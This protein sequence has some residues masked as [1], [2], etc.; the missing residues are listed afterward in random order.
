VTATPEK[1]NPGK[2]SAVRHSHPNHIAKYEGYPPLPKHDSSASGAKV[3][4]E[5]VRE[6][7]TLTLEEASDALVVLRDQIRAFSTKHFKYEMTAEEKQDWPLADLQ[8]KYPELVANCAYI[9][10]GS[11]YG[12]RQ[13]FTESYCRPQLVNGLLGHYLV[14]HVFKHTCFG[15]NAKELVD[16][17]DDVLK[18][19]VHWDGFVRSKQLAIE[20]SAI[21]AGKSIENRAFDVFV[22]VTTL[23]TR[24]LSTIEPFLPS[25]NKAKA[26]TE[27]DLREILLH[28][29][30]LA[31]AL[32]L[33][34]TN[35]TI[36]RFSIPSKHSEYQLGGGQNC[37]NMARVDATQHHA[38][39]YDRDELRVKIPC[40]PTIIATVP[41]GPD[42]LDFAHDPRLK[43]RAGKASLPTFTGAPEDNPGAFVTEVF[44]TPSDVYCEWT[45]L[46]APLQH[47]HKLTL[48]QAIAQAKKERALAL[49][50]P[51]P[52]P[53]PWRRTAGYVLGAAAVGGLAAAAV[54]A[55]TPSGRRLLLDTAKRVADYAHHRHHTENCVKG[56]VNQII[57]DAAAGLADKESFFSRLGKIRLPTRGFK[58]NL[59]LRNRVS[60]PNHP[61]FRQTRGLSWLDNPANPTAAPSSKTSE[62]YDWFPFKTAPESQSSNGVRF[63]FGTVAADGLP[64]PTTGQQE[65]IAAK[66]VEKVAKR[67]RPAVQLQP[68]YARWS[69]IGII[70]RI[71]QALNWYL[72]RR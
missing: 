48:W 19:H 18:R 26:A 8:D 27:T 37:L 28:A 41:S 47:S 51:W 10:D 34:G 17:E 7:R 32:R 29:Q 59:N 24:I 49:G 65:S 61:F 44:I 64:Q 23:S 43:H 31:I 57:D 52:Y 9:A 40:W 69:P 62:M 20:I 22:A 25:C 1:K 70:H 72:G 14:E 45:P 6:S 15:L 2:K 5:L 30:A 4:E 16:L 42:M 3:L 12:W 36:F 60:K 35:R 54:T 33:T 55:C 38:P 71:P 58:L 53:A 67:L 11:Q 46:A 56:S 39:D 66:V 68:V 13:L 50:Q 21:L 63:P